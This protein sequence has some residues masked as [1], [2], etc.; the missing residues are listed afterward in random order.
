MLVRLVDGMD[1]FFFWE[2]GVAVISYGLQKANKE[3][4]EVTV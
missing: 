3:R 4:L 1:K 2:L